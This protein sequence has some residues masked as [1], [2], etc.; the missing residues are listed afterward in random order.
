MIQRLLKRIQEEIQKQ[1][2]RQEDLREEIKWHKLF[3]SYIENEYPEFYEEASKYADN[4]V[5]DIDE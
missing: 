3:Q 1:E 2:Q 5:L 4:E